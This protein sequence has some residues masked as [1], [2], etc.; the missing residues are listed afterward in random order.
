MQQLSILMTSDTHGFW[1]KAPENAERS[2]L[3][4]AATIE[5]LKE[6]AKHP[7]LT[8]DLGDFIQGSSFATYCKQEAGDGS[9]FARA[10]NKIGYDY[11]L[12][13]NHEFNFGQDYRDNILKQL[14]APILCANIVFQETGQPAL[15]QPYVITEREGIRI[16]II[17]VTTE[18]IPHWELPAHYEGL[19][20]L[21]AYQV[22]KKYAEQIRPQVDVLILA[23]HGGFERDLDSFEPL[24]ALTGENRGAEMLQGIPGLDVLLT[25]H[26]HRVI[27]QQV[28]QTWVVQP[29]FAGQYVAEV[30]LDLDQDHRVVSGQASLHETSQTSP[31]QAV[32][33]V[34]EPELSQGVAWLNQVLGEAP[35]LPVTHDAFEARI[36]G[37][38]YI[39]FLNQLQ[40]RE[41]GADFSAIAL[42]NE[43]FK[44]FHGPIT[45]EILLASYPYYNLIATVEVSGQ[46]IKDAL[47]FDLN[48]LVLD[49]DG[50][51]AINPSYI[52]PKPKHYN[53]D[54]FSGLMTTV[55]LTQP[56][57]QRVV[58]IVDE[59]KGQEL[60]LDATYTL[61]LTQYRACGGGDYHMFSSDQM[62]TLSKTDLAT[63]MKEALAHF[64]P[65]DWEQI[66]N[67]Y[68][69][70]TWL[71]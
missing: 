63:L 11:Q 15:G 19:A 32:R 26:Q 37:H 45:N 5:K 12:I 68:Q 25:G 54:V 18:Y 3:N 46:T 42:V 20:F 30:T 28:G 66:N 29:G 36:Y 9:V 48:Y 62:K 71:Q 35:L 21:D 60:D 31:S 38:P 52:A 61:A 57:G 49:Q 41:T 16:G 1:L 47:E 2:L 69:H 14:E 65:E 43:A 23:Y 70:F 58:S 4:T 40:L 17:G 55:D 56:V 7:V 64:G 24:E 53:F 44:D 34:M 39:E 59:R 6:E 22:A 51:K 50:R 8:I 13:G 10:M 67:H 27:C 33:E